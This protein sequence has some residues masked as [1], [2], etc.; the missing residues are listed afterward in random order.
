MA[1]VIPLVFTEGRRIVELSVRRN[2]PW[3]P[4]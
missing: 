1:A 4:A 2:Y 3:K